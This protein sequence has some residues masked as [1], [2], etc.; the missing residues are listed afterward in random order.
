MIFLSLKLIFILKFHTYFKLY[1]NNTPTSNFIFHSA[2]FIT[3]YN[4]SE[5]WSHYSLLYAEAN[6]KSI[7]E[8]ETLSFNMESRIVV[9]LIRPTIPIKSLS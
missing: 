9:V 8:K 4:Q 3:S 2:L 7:N 1:E 5:H 6:G